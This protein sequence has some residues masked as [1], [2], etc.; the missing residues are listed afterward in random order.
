MLTQE[1]ID[2]IEKATASERRAARVAMTPATWASLGGLLG[3]LAAASCCVIPFGLFTLG[4]SGAWIG[5]L[6][7]LAPYQPVFLAVAIGLLATGFVLTY[8]RH[9]VACADGGYCALPA[10][11]RLATVALW[12]ATA[13]VAA[14]LVFPY[15]VRP[16][17]DQ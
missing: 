14:A 2:Q 6:T 17:L 3:A 4:V 16:F 13:L 10:S 8:R 12:M 7:R 11:R 9:Q 5:T 15:V 1:P